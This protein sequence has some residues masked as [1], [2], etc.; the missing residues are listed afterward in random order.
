MP[1]YSIQHVSTLHY[2][3]LITP[4]LQLQLHYTNYTTL[5]VQLH[6][7]TTTATTALHHTT[8]SSCGEGTTATISKNTTPTTFRSISG[9]ALPSVVHSNQPL[10]YV[11][12]FWNFRHRLVRHYTGIFTN[13]F[14]ENDAH[15]SK[16]SIHEH[17][18]LLV[19][20]HP[21]VNLENR[22]PKIN[23]L[24]V[25]GG[26]PDL[27]MDIAHI[28]PNR[29]CLKIGYTLKWPVNSNRKIVI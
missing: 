28:I 12:Y 1:P 21:A 14:S 26:E 3:T 19:P 11:S 17:G 20:N 5:Q 29:V 27:A 25:T 2:I 9:F 6:Y 24:V 18:I 8:S 4:Q 7:A 13:M 15:V 23:R 10:L 22:I 16:Y